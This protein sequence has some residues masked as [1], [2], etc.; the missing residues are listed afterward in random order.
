MCLVSRPQV[1]ISPCIINVYTVVAECAQY[2]SS[3]ADSRS[4]AVAHSI[5]LGNTVTESAA[6]HES[7][8]E[9]LDIGTEPGD[10]DIVEAQEEAL[11]WSEEKLAAAWSELREQ[12][13]DTQDEYVDMDTTLPVKPPTGPRLTIVQVCI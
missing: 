12:A 9:E 7:V 2:R 5:R 4:A 3:S 6:D 13:W 11:L 1:D 10:D 8:V